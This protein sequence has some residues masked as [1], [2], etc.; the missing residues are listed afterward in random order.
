VNGPLVDAA[1]ARGLM[2]SGSVLAVPP[3]DRV[4][5]A[6]ALTAAG[7]WTHADVM[8]G[9]YRGQPGL[10]THE[11]HA[12]S[13][14]PGVHLDVHL[15]C[16]D[17][18]ERAR[19]LPESGVRRLTVQVDGASSP[20]VI[21]DIAHIADEL[22]LAIDPG[23]CSLNVLDDM[24]DDVAGFLVMLTPPGQ[25]GH[26]ADLDR[27]EAV[28]ALAERGEVGV[29]GGVT[30]SGVAAIAHAGARYLVAGRALLG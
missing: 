3:A 17:A 23:R 27:L 19:A 11:I 15:M 12:L 20:A 10:E 7:M 29:D 2:L 8:T 1:R 4:D 6:R 18:A 9:R 16:E 25:P 30:Q 24:P 14:V 22:W 5:A 28:T 13:R 21:A 26:A